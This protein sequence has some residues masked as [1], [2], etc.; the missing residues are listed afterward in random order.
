MRRAPGGRTAGGSCA[1]S[2]RDARLARE[3]DGLLDR[4]LLVRGVAV[5]LR[6][7]DAHALVRV[8]LLELQRGLLARLLAAHVPLVLDVHAFVGRALGAQRL[9]GL[10]GTVI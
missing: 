10:R 2:A 9:A 3:V 8:G 5:R 7:D 4:D 6:D 1:R